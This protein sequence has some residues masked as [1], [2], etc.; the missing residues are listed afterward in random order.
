MFH[1]RY[2]FSPHSFS[3]A[4]QLNTASWN[5][6]ETEVSD[7]LRRG[8]DPDHYYYYTLHE[9]CRSNHPRTALTLVQWGADVRRRRGG[10]WTPLHYACVNNS[11]ACVKVL[12]EH[13]SPTSEPG[14]V[15]S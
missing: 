9:A 13:H 6:Q 2:L 15:C 7:L 4:R 5:G 14:C 8:A 11:I 1:H 12:L 10:G 3:L